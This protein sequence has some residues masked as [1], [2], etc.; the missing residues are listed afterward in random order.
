MKGKVISMKKVDIGY[1][2]SNNEPRVLNEFGLNI[3]AKIIY[4]RKRAN[5]SQ[6]AL[7]I[8]INMNVGYINRLESKKDFLPSLDV[9]KRIIDVCGITV[10]HFFYSDIEHYE[11][12]KVII[13][14]LKN[15]P[16]DKREALL[17]LL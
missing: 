8:D 13:D 5:L 1:N 10:E 15:L 9:L 12:D 16:N 11:E 17:K 4:F 14:K 6:K 7:S 3:I 2:I